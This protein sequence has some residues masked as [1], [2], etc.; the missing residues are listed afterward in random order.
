M[1]NDQRQM[2]VSIGDQ[3]AVDDLRQL[4]LQAA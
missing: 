4:A 2:L 3:L 1:S